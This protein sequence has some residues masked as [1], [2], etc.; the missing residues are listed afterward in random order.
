MSEQRRQTEDMHAADGSFDYPQQG[1]MSNY[2]ESKNSSSEDTGINCS[3][4][5]PNLKNIR[6]AGL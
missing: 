2:R 6:S 1:H 5:P 4:M 3:D